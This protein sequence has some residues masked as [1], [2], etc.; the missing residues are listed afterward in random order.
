VTELFIGES[1]E[2]D[3]AGIAPGMEVVVCVPALLTHRMVSPT[4]TLRLEGLKKLFPTNTTCFT[5]KEG[6]L[7][8]TAENNISEKIKYVDFFI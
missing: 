8:T 7:K 3:P 1:Q 2:A 6:W 5:A 4:L